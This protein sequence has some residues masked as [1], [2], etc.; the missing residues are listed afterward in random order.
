MNVALSPPLTMRN[1]ALSSCTLYLI[2]VYLETTSDFGIFGKCI[3]SANNVFKVTEH[4]HIEQHQI[5]EI[6]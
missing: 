6:H 3:S 4:H 2:L 5:T 1:S